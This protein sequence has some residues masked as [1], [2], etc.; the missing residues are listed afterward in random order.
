MK[1]LCAAA[2]VLLSVSLINQSF[3]QLRKI[4]AEATEAFK[5]KYPNTKNAE[6]RDKVTHFQVNY[7]MDDVRY[8]SKFNSKGEWIQTEKEVGEEGMPAE[9]KDGYSKSKFT[10]WELK[11][12][13][14]VQSKENGV[15]YRLYVRK[16][17]VEKKYL[18]FDKGGRLVRDAITI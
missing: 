12:V 2:M 10:D 4:P 3:A 17:G 15:Q 13:T 6:W 11:S 5:A 8:E 9:V 18:Y 1:K 7:E 16:N 14:W